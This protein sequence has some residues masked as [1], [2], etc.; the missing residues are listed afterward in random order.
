VSNLATNEGGAESPKGTVVSLLG[1]GGESTPG[2]AAAW[3]AGGTLPAEPASATEGAPIEQHGA[4]SAGAA[5]GCAS[6]GSDSNRVS[7]NP[8]VDPNNIP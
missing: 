1:V 6:E 7:A 3:S 5:R 2:A 4:P 8:A